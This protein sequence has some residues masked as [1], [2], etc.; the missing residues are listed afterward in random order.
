MVTLLGA[1]TFLCGFIGVIESTPWTAAQQLPYRRSA[2]RWRWQIGFTVIPV[3]LPDEQ[4]GGS[5]GAPTP[6]TEPTQARPQRWRSGRH[7]WVPRRRHHASF[8]GAAGHEII[9]GTSE[10]PDVVAEGPTCGCKSWR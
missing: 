6:P 8:H 1:L 7:L 3:E 2:P 4:V 5:V 10:S 9:G